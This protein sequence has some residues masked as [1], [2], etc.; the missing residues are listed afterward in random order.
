MVSGVCTHRREGG[1]D[2]GKVSYFL[3]SSYRVKPFPSEPHHLKE[4]KEKRGS[5]ADK[6]MKGRSDKPLLQA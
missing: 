3:K 5:S 1:R 6:E 2:K 4:K